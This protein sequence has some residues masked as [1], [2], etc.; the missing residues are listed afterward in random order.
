MGTTLKRKI[1]TRFIPVA[2]CLADMEG[3]SSCDQRVLAL[4][5][6]ARFPLS[7]RQIVVEVGFSKQA[8]VNSLDRLERLKLI[9]RFRNSTKKTRYE[10]EATLKAQIM[11]ETG[12]ETV[13][14][15]AETGKATGPEIGKATGPEE[16]FDTGPAC[17][18]DL[19][20]VVQPPDQGLV[21]PLY[22]EHKT[23]DKT[24]QEQLVKEEEEGE[25]SPP[26]KQLSE[27]EDSK[28][29][30]TT[31]ETKEE[32]TEEKEERQRTGLLMVFERDNFSEIEPGDVVW[33]ESEVGDIMGWEPLTP[34]QK[35]V[36]RS[37]IKLTAKD[38][39]DSA[40]Y[41]AEILLDKKHSPIPKWA[42]DEARRDMGVEEDYI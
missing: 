25:I 22:K 27:T 31:E 40:D 1:F 11:A 38:G 8:V 16:Q 36:I 12:T 13:Q 34:D 37:A 29:K 30:Q 3:L 9:K 7:I 5:S 6:L 4:L 35:L 14:A 18:S 42:V 19:T 24:V 39:E 41:F 21:Q 28:K 32:T 17:A 26:K 33:F 15:E 10:V 23:E 2:V 20:S